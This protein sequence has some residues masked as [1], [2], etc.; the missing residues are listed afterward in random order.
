MKLLLLEKTTLVSQGAAN[1]RLAY[2]CERVI[3][4]VEVMMMS[5]IFERLGMTLMFV[6][7]CSVSYVI[8][9]IVFTGLRGAF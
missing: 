3:I 8:S 1:N 5:N 7:V 6:A 9:M 2:F 4:Q